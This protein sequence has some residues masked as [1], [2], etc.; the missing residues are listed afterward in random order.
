MPSPPKPWETS[1]NSNTSSAA[2]V[3]A[4]AAQPMTDM[5]TTATTT[6]PSG[7][8]TVPNRPSTMGLGSATSGTTAGLGSAYGGY[9]TTGY[10]GYGSSGYG[11]YGST[12]YG[13]YGYNRL[14]G[15]GSSY[16]GYGSSYGGYGSTYG[17]YG[18]Y[19]SYNRFGYNRFGGAGGMYGE[20]G[21]PMDGDFSLT[22]RMEAST[23]ATFNVIESL[24]GAF[25]GFAQML[26][27]TYMATHSSFMAMVGVAEQFGY[28]RQYLGNI[29]N[30]FRLIRW[31]K[32]LLYRITG[33]TPPPELL[34]EE[35][36]AQEQQQEEGSENTLQITEQ[37]EEDEQLDDSKVKT[38]QLQYRSK[39][40]LIIFLALVT[41]LP[42]ITY[43]LIKRANENRKR[44]LQERML[45]P[46]FGGAPPEVARAVYDFVAENPIELPLRQGETVEVL[47]KVDP[48]TGMPCEWWQ[49]RKPD[50]S[51][52]IFPANY[53]QIVM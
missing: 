9:G 30:I 18:G 25:G 32:R 36:R 2:V 41:G 22:Q 16:G 10:G 48:A 49:G 37:G 4:A 38:K 34:E 21:G 51:F 5:S 50:G 19:G 29:F 46:Q 23:R 6:T 42:Y 53:V 20:M 27:S 28:L 33:R 15:Y 11:G 7:V 1:N 8:P 35:D 14:G 52:G 17:G 40:P 39:R 47:S 45:I 24:V 43:R 26:D 12:G 31:L 3:G 44:Q 13:G